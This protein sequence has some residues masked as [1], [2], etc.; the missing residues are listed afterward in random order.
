MKQR[1]PQATNA[2]YADWWFVPALDPRGEAA[3][4]LR[5]GMGWRIYEV[6]PTGTV[7]IR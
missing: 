6:I 4:L 5:A 3:A 2:G 1:N 7:F